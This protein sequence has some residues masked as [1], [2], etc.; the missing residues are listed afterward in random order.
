MTAFERFMAARNGT[1]VTTP[2]VPEVVTPPVVV[3]PAAPMTAFER[4][5]AARNSR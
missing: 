5:M 1:A 4:F 3:T 2:D